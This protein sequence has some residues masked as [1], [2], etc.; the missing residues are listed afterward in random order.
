MRTKDLE[1]IISNRLLMMSSSNSESEISVY[2]V[3]LS[4][5]LAKINNGGSEADKDKV[6]NYLYEYKLI[7]DAFRME[8]RLEKNYINH[9]KAAIKE[10]RNISK[11]TYY[12]GKNYLYDREDQDPGEI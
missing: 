7:C 6:A 4:Y 10:R 1:D 2:A 3:V 12:D 8:D 5:A 9:L 11:I